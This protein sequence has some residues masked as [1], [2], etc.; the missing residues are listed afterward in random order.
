VL[1]VKFMKHSYR[2]DG[3]VLDIERFSSSGIWIVSSGTQEIKYSFFIMRFMARVPR[4]V[5][6]RS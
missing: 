1:S 6:Q 3:S 4:K 5:S 2:H